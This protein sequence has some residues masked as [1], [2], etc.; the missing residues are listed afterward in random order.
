MITKIYPKLDL[1]EEFDSV[2]TT[3][4]FMLYIY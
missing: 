3:S 1:L 4:V 2:V